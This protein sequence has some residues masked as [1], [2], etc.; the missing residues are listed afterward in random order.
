[1]AKK[2]STMRIKDFVQAKGL[3]NFPSM[4]VRRNTGKN[5]AITI[6]LNKKH[7]VLLILKMLSISSSFSSEK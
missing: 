7:P 2:A 1:M 4:P 6:L 5:D 3:N